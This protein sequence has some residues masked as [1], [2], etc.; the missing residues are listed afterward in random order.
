MEFK[1]AYEAKIPNEKGLVDYTEEEN[2]VWKTL[3]ERQ[4][5]LMPGHASD[6][7]IRGLE[8]INF[9]ID[10]VP[11]L[12]DVNAR[13]QELTN[14]QVAPVEAL[15]TPEEFFDLLVKR[16]FP[17]ATFIR[18]MAELDYVK[19]PDIFHELFG[20]CPMLTDPFIA[21]MVQNY[22]Q[23]VIRMPTEDWPLLQ[24]MFWFTVEFG[25]INTEQGL[26][27]WGG[28]ILSSPG[29]SVYSVES[30]I[31][32]RRPFDPITVFR[33]PYR[34]DMKQTVYYVLDSYQQLQDFIDSD[35]ADLIRQ[36]RELGE[37]P[38][39]FPVEK[40]NPNIHIFCC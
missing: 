10:T 36:T 20:H 31:P 35:V 37:L 38:A 13:L 18:C 8:K 34:I 27:A 15:I 22:A 1:S 33:T 16:I 6:E 7:H 14:W 40:D 26:R 32:E 12:P 29:E 39:T 4:I 25:L 21:D 11:Q 19:E 9:S 23:M 30:D 17:A 3:Y 24:R 2:L 5:K 28:G